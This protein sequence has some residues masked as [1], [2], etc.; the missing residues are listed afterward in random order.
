MTSVNGVDVF[1]AEDTPLVGQELLE[2]G[3]GG[4]QV[5]GQSLPIGE[6]VT[7]GQG[8]RMVV[9]EVV[10][11][12][13]RWDV[14]SLTLE[15][16]AGKRPI[17]RGMFRTPR[18]LVLAGAASRAGFVETPQCIYPDDPRPSWAG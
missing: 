1:G 11:P 7:G 8:V 15:R 13:R 6:T 17:G 16:G 10:G 5:P 3:N 14:R 4:D 9:A 18:I 2:R 12:W